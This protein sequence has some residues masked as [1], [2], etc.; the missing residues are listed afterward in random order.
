M[1]LLYA[2]CSILDGS[3]NGCGISDFYFSKKKK[4]NDTYTD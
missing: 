4:K 3:E 1:L 2:L